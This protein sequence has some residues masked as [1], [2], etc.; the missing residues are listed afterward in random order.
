ILETDKKTN[1]TCRIEGITT[2]IDMDLSILVSTDSI[3]VYCALIVVIGIICFLSFYSSISPIIK[4]LEGAIKRIK[5]S[6]RKKEAFPADYY[7]FKEWM[8]QTDYLRDS[9]REFEE[10]L[11]IPGEDFDDEKQII[12]NTQLTAV[13][14]NQKNILWHN[15][16]MRFY[17]AL[18]N[19]LTGLGIIGTFIGLAIGIYIA[20]PGLNSESIDDA[21]NALNQLLSGASLAFFTSIAGLST[22]LIFSVIEKKRIHKFNKLC[23]NLVAEI[24]AR[25][26]Y[27][28]AERLASK[29]LNEFQKQSLALESFANDLAVSLG[30]VIEQQVSRPMIAAINELKE[31]QKSAND[32]TLEKLISEFSSSITGAAGEEMKAF[33]STMDSV[34]SNLESQMTAMTKNQAEMQEASK[35]A[36]KDMAAAMTEGG[37]QIKE[38]IHDAVSSLSDGISKSLDAVSVQLNSAAEMLSE[39]LSESINSFDTVLDKITDVTQKY[40]S[41]SKNTSNLHEELN[42]SIEKANETVTLAGEVNAAFNDSIDELTGFTESV[43]NSSTSIKESTS[44]VSTFIENIESIH[45]SI[46]S[47]WDS[48]NE[49]FESVD[50][51]LSNSISSLKEGLDGY[52]NSTNDYVIGLDKHAAQVVQDLASAV[53]EVNDAIESINESLEFQKSSFL[54]SINLISDKALADMKYA[55]SLPDQA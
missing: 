39:K 9:W 11:L 45:G 24:D 52:A 27:F 12:L 8:G 40:E 33:A 17:N 22:S 18:P 10:T 51:S 38:E 34:S 30:Q 36:V 4:E 29:S 46:K 41:I 55:S 28:S 2:M 23:Q 20:A 53:Q 47:H 31:E 49:R 15:V 43:S 21:K 44:Q 6:E 48:Y 32:E 26:E 35:Q 42:N 14:F 19:M 7:E 1:L 5:Q 16:N 13:H 50:I 54:E 37:K 3:V 25:V